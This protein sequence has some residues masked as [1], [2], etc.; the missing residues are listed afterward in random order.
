MGPWGLISE[1]LKSYQNRTEPNRTKQTNKTTAPSDESL[2]PEADYWHERVSVESATTR[3]ITTIMALTPTLILTK[4]PVDYVYAFPNL[5]YHHLPSAATRNDPPL[6]GSRFLLFHSAL[7]LDRHSS[8][9]LP[10]E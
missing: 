4:A 2:T 9:T 3:N 8:T 10:T 1:N 5:F 6:I 7:G